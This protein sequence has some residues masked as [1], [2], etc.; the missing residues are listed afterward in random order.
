MLVSL[1]LEIVGLCAGLGKHALYRLP[2]IQIA[3][4]GDGLGFYRLGKDALSI[5]GYR[6]DRKALEAGT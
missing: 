5:L 6:A 2:L 3:E 1:L 4:L